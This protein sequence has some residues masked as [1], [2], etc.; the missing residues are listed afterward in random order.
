MS[1]S[2]ICGLQ[3]NSLAVKA[4]MGISRGADGMKQEV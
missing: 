2:E 1:I 4:G 3:D